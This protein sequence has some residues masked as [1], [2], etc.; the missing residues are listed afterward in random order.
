MISSGG[1]VGY[2]A[3]MRSRC[4]HVSGLSLLFLSTLLTLMPLLPGQVRAQQ[5][6]SQAFDE[7]IDALFNDGWSIFSAPAH[8]DSRD[9]LLTALTAGSTFAAYMIDDEVRSGVHEFTQDGWDIPLEVGE[10]YGSGIVSG[11]LG[12][13]LI[14]ASA[15]NGDDDTRVAGRMVLQSLAYSIT[16]TEALKIIT[17]R[18]RPETGEAKSAFHFFRKDGAHHSFPSGHTTAAFALSSTLS[19]RVGSTPLSIVLYALSTLTAIERIAD[20]RHWFSDTVIGAVIGSAVGIAVVE[21][22]E[23]RE[24]QTSE[25]VADRLMTHRPLLQYSITF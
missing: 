4:P 1:N 14:A 21:F 7:D 2:F 6:A 11:G 18:G 3:P 13:G 8:F 12:L 19:R 15:L 22:E 9:W 25:G 5:S 17:G 20:D 24:R 10:W 16:I 23:E